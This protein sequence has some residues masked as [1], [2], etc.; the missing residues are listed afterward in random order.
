MNSRRRVNSTI[1]QLPFNLRRLMYRWL[2]K[3]LILLV[4]LGAGFG[5]ATLRSRR[6]L[7]R[8]QKA[9]NSQITFSCDGITTAFRTHYHSSD[10]QDLRYGC[11][12]HSSVAEAER[13][14]HDEIRPNYKYVRWPDGHQTKIHLVQRAETFDGAG[15]KIGE[16]AVL[17]NGELYWTDGPRFHLIYAPS[18]E[19]ALLF[20]NSRAWAWEGCMK[21][22]PRND[23]E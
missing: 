18:V 14:F 11:Y 9:D 3:A 15:N 10:G 21:L 8:S 7:L 19:Y 20:E 16:R 23:S 13:Y 2:L 12:E 1:R 4:T 22:P 5:L 6:S 17:D